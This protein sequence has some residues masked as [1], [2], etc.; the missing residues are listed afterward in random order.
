MIRGSISSRLTR[1]LSLWIGVLWLVMCIGVTYY[2]QREIDDAN[3]GSLVT[4]ATRLLELAAH[5][6]GEMREHAVGAIP[7]VFTSLD[8][9]TEPHLDLHSLTYQILSPKG[10]VLLRSA[11]APATQIAQLAS[12]G[13]TQT[14]RWRVYT[15]KHPREPLYIQVA[16][17]LAHR[18]EDRRDTLLWLLLPL[19][20]VFPLIAWLIR[21]ITLR[22][23]APVE[24][25]VAEIARRGVTNMDPVGGAELPSE[26]QMICESTNHLLMR[27]KEALDVERSLAANAAHELRTPLAAARL[28]LA[29]ALDHSLPETARIAMDEA[30][31]SLDRLAR[32]AEKLLQM[33]RAESS[34]TFT[35][36]TVDLGRLACDVAQEFWREPDASRRLK[37]QLSSDGPIATVGDADALAIA[38]RNLIE[39]ALRYAP[40]ASVKVKVQEPAV[41]IVRDLGPGVDAATLSAMSARHVR[42]T[43]DQTGFGLGLSIVKT[44]VERHGGTMQL[45]SPPQGHKTGLAVVLTFPVADRPHPVSSPSEPGTSGDHIT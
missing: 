25:L 24:G 8:V 4:S 35:R 26:M 39:N 29:S 2:V 45:F 33:S 37:V 36:E 15:L 3:D 10:E 5:E 32:R 6:V 42:R 16:D 27:L 12:I 34:A 38:L 30:A 9:G 23:L 17:S 22:S 11:D 7:G 1:D 43:A 13:F 31:A 19:L 21:R 44:V 40:D 20:A 18:N 14:D 28:R 41:V